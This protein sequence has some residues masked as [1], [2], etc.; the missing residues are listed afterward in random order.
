MTNK[1][2]KRKF[3][4]IA[5]LC[6]MFVL[7]GCSSTGKNGKNFQNEEKLAVVTTIYPMYEF[8]LNIAGDK[9][10]VINL[11]PAG[12]EPHDF[13]LSAKDMQL[14]EQAD[15]F[16]YNGAGME[17]FVDKTLAAVSNEDLVVVETAGKAGSAHGRFF[18]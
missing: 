15:M 4:I 7:T 12:I 6:V 16:I 1:W 17:H 13:E 11:V 14:M 3:C 2:K 18:T 9:A 5:M 10:E 8:A